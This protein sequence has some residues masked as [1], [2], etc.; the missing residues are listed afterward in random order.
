MKIS[1]DNI[2]VSERLRE[3]DISKVAELEESIKTI[4]LLQP[5][6]V[7]TDFN[8]LSG[9][10]RL[11]AFKNIGYKKIECKKVNLSEQKNKLV[12]IEENLIRKDLSV[13]EKS[14]H[15]VLRESIL[16]DLGLRVV[17]GDNRHVS[18][19]G[20]FDTFTLADRMDLTKRKY[21]RIKQIHKINAAA[22]L[23]LKDS[24][25]DDNLDVLLLIERL[26][27]DG[28]QLE[29]AKRIKNG[30]SGKIR[31]LIKD[32]Q[33]EIKQDEV[34]S[35]LDDYENSIDEKVKLYQGDFRKE[36]QN[37]DDESIDLIFTDGPY[38]DS[39]EL[40]KS[41]SEIGSRVLKDGGSLLCYLTQSELPDVLSVMSEYLNYYWIISLKHGGATGR[42]GRGVFVEWKPILWFVKNNRTRTE[43]VADFVLSESSGK[44]YHEWEQSEVESDY[45]ISHLTNVG[46]V[47]LD[48]MMGSGTTGISACKCNRKFIGIEKDKRTFG[49][50]K[51]R[52]TNRSIL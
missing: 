25:I 41:M 32:I 7:D 23:I 9:N 31:R 2:K 30:Y 14:E 13:I 8:L 26:R 47:V 11:Q 18:K 37:I 20:R 12:E 10:H 50:A 19:H 17:R 44:I 29:V 6:V 36:S 33:N 27:D 39:I 49:I 46:G 4:G 48:L 38:L 45:Y 3:L 52:I 42:H 21:Q 43:Y 51:G 22:R 5:I 35:Q 24:D 15:M 1:V 16:E 28:L 40:Y 34:L